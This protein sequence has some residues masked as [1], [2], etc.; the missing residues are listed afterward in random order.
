MNN[1]SIESS[2]IQHEI[3]S[4]ENSNRDETLHAF[5]AKLNNDPI[6][7]REAMTRKNSENWRIAVKEELNSMKK[8]E[9]WELVDRPQKNCTNKRPNIIDSKWIFKIKT[10]KD[11]GKKFKARLVIRGFKDI[12]TYEL[13]ET[14]APVS[15]LVLVRTVLAIINHYDL[16]VCQLDVKTAFLNGTIDEEIFMEI[17]EGVDESEKLR[18]TK[19]CK[20]KRALYGLRISPKRWNEKFTEIVGL[21]GLVNDDHDPCL[22]TWRDGNRLA[23]LILYVDDMLIAS[24]DR[25]KLLNIKTKL[26]E[27]FEITDLGEPQD[28]LG[29]K[30]R[31]DRRTKSMT[32]TQTDYIERI[33]EN[34]DFSD[35]HPKYTS[36]VTRQVSNRERKDREEE[37]DDNFDNTKRQ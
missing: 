16:E 11:G 19:V 26:K 20:I 34:Y 21:L 36:M 29:M 3:S 18:K 10:E 30:I 24:N 23:I 32:I 14:Y 15:R 35:I 22:F 28:F 7:F 12:N 31:R 37:L 33:L 13:K 2:D 8:N 1:E 5:F 6:N 4:T 27:V 25:E 17:P 9:M